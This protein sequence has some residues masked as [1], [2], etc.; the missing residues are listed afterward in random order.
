[1]PS[2]TWIAAVVA[3]L[4]LAGCGGDDDEDQ[5]RGTT[6]A[7]AT[8]PPTETAETTEREATGGAEQVEFP[9]DGGATI[10][11][12]FTPSGRSGR[13]PAVVLVHQFS[14]D[15][16]DW[17]DLVPE[18]N[19]RGFH[20]LAYDIRGMGESEAEDPGDVSAFPL[21]VEA[22]IGASVGAGT[23]FV[24]AGSG[25]GVARTVALSPSAGRGLD[26]DDVDSPRGVLA[27][28]SEIGDSRELAE[29]TEEPKRVVQSQADGHGIALLSDESVRA[30]IFDW[31]EP[32]A[33]R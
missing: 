31:L 14:S 21:D 23:V 27:D 4:A 17:D 26:G 3:A 28:E 30:A 33:A 7:R 32:L 5:P 13:G 16:S 2:R 24:A 8:P 29:R 25:Y 19:E 9:A 6:P 15:R 22:A 20:A 12:T 11:A 18:L 1:M 10:R